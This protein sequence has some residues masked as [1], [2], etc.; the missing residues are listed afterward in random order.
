VTLYEALTGIN[1]FEAPT[2]V[3]TMNRI[4][5]VTPPDPRTVRTGIRPALA[6]LLLRALHRDPAQRVRSAAELRDALR[7]V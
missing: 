5:T 3:S 4:L 2:I 6:T 7:A 1:P